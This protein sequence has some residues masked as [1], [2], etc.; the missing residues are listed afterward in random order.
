MSYLPFFQTTSEMV[1]LVAEI[2]ELTG[3]FAINPALAPNPTVRK[4]NQLRSVH[5]STF[6]EGNTLTLD[7]VTAVIDGKR[8]MAPEREIFEV[9]Q[10][11]AAYDALAGMDP[12][13][14]DDLL[15]A[16]GIMMAGLTRDVGKLRTVEVGVYSGTRL[17]HAGRPAAELPE[18]M[19]ELFA[20]LRN[21][22]DHPLIKGCFFHCAFEG[23][24]PFA[25]GN[26]RTGRLW[27]SLINRSWRDEL[28]WVPVESMVAQNQQEYYRVLGISNAGE[29]TEFIEFMLEMTRDALTDVVISAESGMET[30]ISVGLH[31]GE[32][33]PRVGDNVGEALP[34]VGENVGE[35][36]LLLLESDPS[37]SAKRMAEQLGLSARHV[38]RI[39]S[40]L[41]SQGKIERVGPARGGHW[42]VRE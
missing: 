15:N 19:D 35:N 14:L 38:E 32:I 3:A 1:N 34:Q 5:S 7:E 17:L 40:S 28:A 21:S 33:I 39:L 9:T 20:W 13:S 2:V 24:H 26:G 41:K 12:Y 16:H 10:A 30:G 4:V 8:V 22:T 6:I 37:I 42:E 11:F 25:D 27:H 18:A 29:A 31:V 23:I 36:I